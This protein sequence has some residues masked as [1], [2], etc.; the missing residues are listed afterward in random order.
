MLGHR[1]FVPISSTRSGNHDNREKSKSS[2]KG[3]DRDTLINSESI[4]NRV[5]RKRTT[6][7]F[8]FSPSLSSP[9]F[10]P[11]RP[12]SAHRGEEGYLGNQRYGVKAA[13]HE[14][15][16]LRHRM[17]SYLPC[18]SLLSPPTGILSIR[19]KRYRQC[20]SRNNGTGCASTC[21]LRD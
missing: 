6:T 3:N 19:G 8:L 16:V 1:F 7:F 9:L 18:L 2:S 13:E 17:Y 11:P 10:F 5:V 14:Q 15:G 21:E 12:K 4:V 20:R